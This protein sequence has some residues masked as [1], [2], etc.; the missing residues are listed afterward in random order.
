MLYIIEKIDALYS[1]DLCIII[2]F[3][4]CIIIV[5]Y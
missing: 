5:F 2:A 1:R 3:D 4:L